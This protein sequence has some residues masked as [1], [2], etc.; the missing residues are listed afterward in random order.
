LFFSKSGSLAIFAAIRRVSSQY[1]SLT[2]SQFA[3]TLDG[4]EIQHRQ[5]VTK[6]GP[7]TRR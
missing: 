2:D 1:P 7:T 3:T 4:D 6:S 5:R